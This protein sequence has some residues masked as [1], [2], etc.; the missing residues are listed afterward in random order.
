MGH[1]HALQDAVRVSQPSPGKFE[2]P[3]WD[4]A[5][6]KKVKIALLQLGTT[7]SDSR[8]EPR[9]LLRQHRVNELD[10]HGTLADGRGHAFGASCAHVADG[11]HAGPVRLEEEGCTVERPLR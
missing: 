6:L 10:A 1:V 11:E 9:A 7:I 3:N 4:G 8:D 5:S 2:V